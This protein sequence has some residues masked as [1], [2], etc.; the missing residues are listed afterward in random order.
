MNNKNYNKFYC[1]TNNLKINI[2]IKKN[3]KTKN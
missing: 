3:G 1:F 2:K